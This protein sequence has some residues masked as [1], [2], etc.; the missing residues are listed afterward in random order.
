VALAVVLF[1]LSG[2]NGVHAEPVAPKEEPVVVAIW[3][4]SGAEQ[5]ALDAP[6][7]VTWDR[8]MSASNSFVV[9]GP[10]G[11]VP[12][13]F[14][15]DEV[16]FKTTFHPDDDLELH[17]RYDVI[18]EDQADVG[19]LIQQDPVRWHFYTVTPTSVSLVEFSARQGVEETWW[20]GAWPWMMV[21]VSLISLIGFVRVW[22]Q[23]PRYGM[24]E[25]K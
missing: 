6:I 22:R 17:S 19:G 16:A 5:V 14:T 1:F 21:L 20:W 12:G 15:Y 3:P 4:S 24:K 13:S 2:L 11:A 10:Q 9:L 23:R 8:P 25:P 7:S 18:V